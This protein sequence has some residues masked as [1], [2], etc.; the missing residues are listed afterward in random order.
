MKAETVILWDYFKNW[1]TKAEGQT[2]KP[3]KPI[4]ISTSFPL[5]VR[6]KQRLGVRWHMHGLF[7]LTVN[8]LI[9]WWVSSANYIYL[10]E[11]SCQSCITSRFSYSFKDGKDKCM[12]CCLW[13]CVFKIQL[14]RPK[15]FSNKIRWRMTCTTWPTCFRSSFMMIEMETGFWI[16]MLLI[17][18]HN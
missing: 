15:K 6:L 2:A 14:S 11:I 10:L 5:L 18:L 7:T 4:N 12:V 13:N 9:L 1:I 17:G 16:S 8:W 3:N